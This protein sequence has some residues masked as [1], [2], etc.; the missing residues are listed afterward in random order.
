MFSTRRRR[1][2]AGSL[3]GVTLGMLPR[4]V[5]GLPR[6]VDDPFTLGVASGYPQPGGITLWTRLAPRPYEPAGG[7]ASGQALPVRWEIAADERF[8]QLVMHGD[9]L[10]EP[11]WGHSV[12][13]DI[14]GLQPGRSY[15]YRFRSGDAVSP[16]GRTRTAPAPGG[17]PRQL[18]F[19]LASCQHYEHGYYAAYRHMLADDLDFVVHVGDYI[20]EGSWGPVRIR[21]HVGPDPKTLD[22]YRVRY[23]CY[24][25]DPD[26][27]AAHAAYPWFNVWDDHEVENDYARDRSIYES[28]S[29]AFLARRAAAYQA[30]YEHLP[31]PAGMRPGPAGMR[32]H[33]AARWGQ[34]AGLALLDTRQ[35]RSY[36]PCRRSAR[37]RYGRTCGD[38]QDASATL[39]GTRQEAWLNDVCRHGNARWNLFAQQVLMARAD[40]DPGPAARLQTQ[41]W[42]AYPAARTRFLQMLENFKVANPVVLS[43]DVHSF[44]VNDLKQDF[45]TPRAPAVAAEIVTSSISSWSGDDAYIAQVRRDAPHVKFA[46]ARFRGYVRLDVN[47]ARIQADL[48]AVVRVSDPASRGFTLSS[49]VVENG[50][51]GIARA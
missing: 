37:D 43:G 4:A 23:A 31:L 21:D 40:A 38:W 44:W 12:H 29:A 9:V 22:E 6:F 7:L 42:D 20:Y 24:R 1:V 2:L 49:W 5:V 17:L 26:L 39:L 18:R 51:A 28:D 34:L 16:V 19:A 3:A 13:V 15:C 32:I 47:P 36:P 48:R 10:A 27:R 46:T 41:A 25:S 35:Y 30:F 11:R 8:R 33:S 14:R 50:R 45:G